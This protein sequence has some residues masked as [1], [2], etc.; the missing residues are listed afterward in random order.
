MTATP[1]TSFR[2]PPAIGL[3][4]VSHPKEGQMRD[5]ETAIFRGV[6]KDEQLVRLAEEF[7]G[8]RLYIPTQFRSTHRIAKAVGDDCAAAL[9]KHLGGVAIRVPLAVDLRIR[10]YLATGVK[11]RDIRRRLCMTETSLI[12]AINRLGLR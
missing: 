4:A 7:G 11:R 1:E 9:V 3:A 2:P 6:L 12:K 5:T 8:D 10:H